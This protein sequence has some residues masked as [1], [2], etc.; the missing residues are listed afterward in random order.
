MIP[1]MNSILSLISV[2][3]RDKCSYFNRLI[4][5]RKNVGHGQLWNERDILLIQIT[6]LVLEKNEPIF[7]NGDLYKKLCVFLKH[8]KHVFD[9]TVLSHKATSVHCVRKLTIFTI[10]QNCFFIMFFYQFVMR[11]SYWFALLRYSGVY[12]FL[13]F[14]CF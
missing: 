13:T 3:G 10:L 14:M 9:L 1:M 4:L 2:Q 6:F 8:I 5:Y 11:L 12:F 7:L